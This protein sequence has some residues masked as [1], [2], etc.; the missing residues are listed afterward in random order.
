MAN[1]Q[2]APMYRLVVFDEVDDPAAVRDL[3]CRVTGL[4]PTDAMQWVTR[5]PGVWPKP[6]SAAD[7]KDLL[8]GLYHL[9]VAAEAWLVEKFPEIS[10][11]RTVHDAA[12]LAEGFRV[13]GL[14]GEP[15]HWVPWD[16][17][18]L[19]AAGM[20]EGEDEYRDVRPPAWPSAAIAAIR[21]LTFRNPRPF[22]RKSRAQRVSRDPVGEVIIVRKDP[23]IAFRVVADKMNYAYLGSRLSPSTATNFPLFV[24]DLVAR[25]ENAY[26]TP[27]TRAF[28]GHPEDA[29]TDDCVF[30]SS[31]ALLEYATHRLLW[32][33]YTKDRDAARDAPADD[34]S[35][36]TLAD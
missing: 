30:P 20:V 33:W 27:S 6:L 29:E 2:G 16:K 15:T 17:V 5:A 1:S 10:P 22:E 31:Q 19:I 4:H 21:A 12:C 3:F 26:L 11:A 35:D 9:G 23:R 28:L 8:D 24:A 14:R 36:S 25:A 34:D 32:S 18:E 13:K 7:V